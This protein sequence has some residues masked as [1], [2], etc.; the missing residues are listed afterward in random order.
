MLL[1][2]VVVAAMVALGISCS[3]SDGP[4]VSET[5]TPQALTLSPTAGPTMKCPTEPVG[6]TVLYAAERLCITQI[7]FRSMVFVHFEPRDRVDGHRLVEEAGQ[8]LK[9]HG[10]DACSIYETVVYSVHPAS[11][12]NPI[13][14]ALRSERFIPSFCSS[15]EPGGL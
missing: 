9:A 7:D 5:T 4:T 3:S 1:V 12:D 8:W 15:G 10:L 2:V 11:Y 13:W 6:G 14:L